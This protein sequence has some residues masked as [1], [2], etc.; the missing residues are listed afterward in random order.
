MKTNSLA[1]DHMSKI[2][3]AGV[4]APSGK[5]SSFYTTIASDLF[6]DLRSEFRKLRSPDRA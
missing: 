6:Y 1:G 2:E 5:C 4:V 3:L